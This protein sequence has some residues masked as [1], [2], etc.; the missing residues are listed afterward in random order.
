MF[1]GLDLRVSWFSL[2]EDAGGATI[3]DLRL[4]P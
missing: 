2:S 4:A 3:D 1:T